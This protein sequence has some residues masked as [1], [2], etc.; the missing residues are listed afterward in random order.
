M[1]TT[2]GSVA[3]S[4]WNLDD[5]E[6]RGIPVSKAIPGDFNLDGV[7]DGEDLTMLLSKWGP[8]EGCIEDITLD[9]QVAG[10]DLTIL[11]TNWGL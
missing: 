7:V 10:A 5:V 9:G 2:N 11:L 6:V 3:Y 4:G 1:G 8:C